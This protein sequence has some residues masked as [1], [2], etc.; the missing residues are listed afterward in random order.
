MAI[1]IFY[2]DSIKK[3]EKRNELPVSGT[4]ASVITTDLTETSKTI[5]EHYENYVNNFNN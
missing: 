4:K 5:K 3:N 1:Y 2:P